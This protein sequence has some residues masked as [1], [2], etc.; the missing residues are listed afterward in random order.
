MRSPETHLAKNQRPLKRGFTRTEFSD[1]SALAPNLAKILLAAER[2]G[3]K[4]SIRDAQLAF[5]SKF[6]P[7]A[8]IAR[9]WFGELVALDYGKVQKSGNGKSLIFE[10]TAK[11]TGTKPTMAS[12]SNP[13]N[14]SAST[15]TDP[16]AIS[17]LQSPSKSVGVVDE[18]IHAR[19]QTESI[20]E[21]GLRAV[22]GVVPVDD[23]PSEKIENENVTDCVKFIRA[24]ISGNDPQSDQ[25]PF[26][27]I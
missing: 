15:A 7:N 20:Q 5:T 6:R 1:R 27:K 3:G 13:V 22:V 14:I 8:Q 16:N 10:I 23:H 26:Q 4:I 19:L 12:N 11:S 25:V 9:S 18:M 24:A 17:C 21:K 2:K